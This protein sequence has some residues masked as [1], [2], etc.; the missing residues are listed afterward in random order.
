M[1]LIAKLS[2]G[3]KILKHGQFGLYLYSSDGLGEY[4]AISAKDA[5]KIIREEFNLTIDILN[6]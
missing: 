1:E 2:N 4:R 6:S 5:K 3:N